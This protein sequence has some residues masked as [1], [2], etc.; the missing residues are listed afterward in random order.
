MIVAQASTQPRNTTPINTTKNNNA[1][2]RVPHD[3]SLIDQATVQ[4]RN[5]NPTPINT[6]ANS[7]GNI[8]NPTIR[9]Y[10]K[11][12]IGAQPK[13][14]LESNAPVEPISPQHGEAVENNATSQPSSTNQNHCKEPSNTISPQDGA[15]VENN[16]C[17]SD[18]SCG[19]Q[20]WELDSAAATKQQTYSD[21]NKNAIPRNKA[22]V[23]LLP[24]RFEVIV[25]SAVKEVA[26]QVSL[27][28]APLIN[29]LK[30][31][32]EMLESRLHELT[33]ADIGSN[34][35]RVP[36]RAQM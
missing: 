6:T 32:I 22:E 25:I 14:E 9:V 15:A 3:E 18:A 31:Q 35:T 17:D 4:P 11:E 8:F 24:A 16:D 13:I 19:I 26:E 34:I 27:E 33:Q 29:E 20:Q 10:Q 1:S 36:P 30:R 5:E 2:S 12:L 23:A 28:R 7:Y 21:E